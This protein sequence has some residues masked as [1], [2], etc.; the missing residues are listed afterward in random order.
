MLF[1]PI[2]AL[3]TVQTQNKILCFF[4]FSHQIKLSSFTMK[5]VV[6]FSKGCDV[7]MFF[8]EEIIEQWRSQRGC[9]GWHWTPLTSDRPPWVSPQ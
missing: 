4:F 6:N 8:V 1:E 3:E 5:I 9:P 7:H 2:A